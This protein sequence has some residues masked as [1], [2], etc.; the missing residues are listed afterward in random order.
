MKNLLLIA[1]ALLSI[2][3]TAQGLSTNIQETYHATLGL[4]DEFHVF[5]V[6]NIEPTSESWDELGWEYDD[7]EFERVAKYGEHAMHTW[8]EAG[9]FVVFCSQGG[10]PLGERTFFIINESYV[11]YVKENIP[12]I[13]VD[14]TFVRAKVEWVGHSYDKVVIVR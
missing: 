2:T 3:V 4:A 12:G 14:S 11:D 6:T 5:K 13:Q 7:M 9:V 8:T 10:E 1:A